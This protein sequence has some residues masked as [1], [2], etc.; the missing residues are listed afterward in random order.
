MIDLPRRFPYCAKAAHSLGIWLGLFVGSSTGE[1]SLQATRAN[2]ETMV[3]MTTTAR[4]FTRNIPDPFRR[5]ET[6][7]HSATLTSCEQ[8]CKPDEADVGRQ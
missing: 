8:V 1:P 3:T 4:S 6:W 5:G 2:R 7:L